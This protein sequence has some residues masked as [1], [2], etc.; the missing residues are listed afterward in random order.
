MLRLAAQVQAR[1]QQLTAGRQ[2]KQLL[3]RT[4]G[5]NLSAGWRGT[6]AAV[7]IRDAAHELVGSHSR[8]TLAQSFEASPYTRK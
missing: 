6:Q 2:R 5:L 4:H 3:V 7:G 8:N 1:T